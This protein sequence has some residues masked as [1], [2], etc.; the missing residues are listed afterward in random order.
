M[1]TNYLQP[2][3]LLN[4]EDANIQTLIKQKNWQ[5]LSEFQKV[6]AAYN[7]VRDD[8]KFG[9]NIGDELMATQVLD[10]GFGQCNTKATLLMALL[11]ALN[12]PCRFHGFTIKKQ[13]QKGAITGFAYLIAPKS[14]IHSW[15][16]IY[17]ENQWLNLEGFIIDSKYLTKLQSKFNHVEGDFSGYGVATK[18]FKNPPNIWKGSNTYIQKQGINFDFDIFNDPDAFYQKHG[19]NL[20]GIKKWL[21]QNFI[22]HQMNNDVS[23]IRR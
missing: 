6:E 17:F 3:R 11:R 19:S 13:L 4:F 1:Q 14:I 8:I 16:E 2:T 22:R 10:D 18:N 7:F 9:Y 20:K 5:T 12:I 15:V 21:Y 23:K